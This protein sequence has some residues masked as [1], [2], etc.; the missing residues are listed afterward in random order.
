MLCFRFLNWFSCWRFMVARALFQSNESKTWL[1]DFLSFCHD[2]YMPSILFIFFEK[3][4]ILTCHKKFESAL[5]TKYSWS[6]KLIHIIQRLTLTLI[7][8][9]I[10]QASRMQYSLMKMENSSSVANSSRTCNCTKIR[11]YIRKKKQSN[12][13]TKNQLVSHNKSG[14]SL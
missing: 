3:Q 10:L 6:Q 12:V 11:L 2:T 7:I 9:R 1:A 13:N 5:T 4:H 8:L 14:Q